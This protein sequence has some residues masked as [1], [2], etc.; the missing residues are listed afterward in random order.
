MRLVFLPLLLAAGLA[1]VAALRPG[2]GLPVAW[3]RAPRSAAQ[4][5]VR[6]Y[7]GAEPS[8]KDSFA[9]LKAEVPPQSKYL[10]QLPPPLAK[11]ATHALVP[12]GLLGGGVVGFMIAP[13]S[14]VVSGAVGLLGG[15][16]TSL[17]GA[18]ARRKLTVLK[19]EAAFEALLE[20]LES[21][22]DDFMTLD[23]SR[24]AAI[25][26]SFG[27]EPRLWEDMKGE[28]YERFMLAMLKSPEFKTNELK[29]LIALKDALDMDLATLS[30]AI[31]GAVDATFQKHMLLATSEITDDPESYERMTMDKCIYL[32][33]SVMAKCDTD[34]G[35]EYGMARCCHRLG[36]RLDEI[37]DR[38]LGIA[39]PLYRKALLT[40]TSRVDELGPD[41]LLKAR[42]TLGVDEETSRT[43]HMAVYRDAM[44]GMLSAQPADGD[45]ATTP[46][47]DAALL[48]AA[49][50]EQLAKLKA[51]MMMTD[52]ETDEVE[53]AE[54]EPLHQRVLDD[55]LAALTSG[56]VDTGAAVA[57][58]SRSAEGYLIP[59]G[60]AT[61]ML[62]ATLGSFLVKVYRGA[63]R[64][65]G[66][67]N[68]DALVAAVNDLLLARD[69]VGVLTLELKQAGML[70][71]E[72]DDYIEDAIEAL[73]TSFS[74]MPHGDREELLRSYV[75]N[76]LQ[77]AALTGAEFDF[78]TAFAFRD[79]LVVDETTFDRIYSEVVEPLV[80][81]R[82]VGAVEAG[83]FDNETKVEFD[84]FMNA[85]EVP[86][87]LYRK[88]ATDLYRKEVATVSA[89]GAIYTPSQE[90]KL[91]KMAVFMDVDPESVSKIHGQ[92][93]A[94]SY[95]QAVIEAMGA[96]GTGIID[97]EYHEGLAKLGERLKLTE[98]VQKSIYSK[99]ITAKVNAQVEQ[100]VAE[101]ERSVLSKEELGVKTGKDQGE[102]LFITAKD[103]TLGLETKA[104][105]MLE[106]VN[107]VD[108]FRGNR[109]IQDVPADEDDESSE[110][111]YEYL[112]TAEG[113]VDGRMLRDVYRHFVVNS[114][115]QQQ[116]QS[117][118]ARAERIEAAKVHIGSILGIS[119][120]EQKE[121]EQELGKTVY[122]QYVDN[123]LKTKGKLEPQDMQ[124]LVNVQQMLKMDDDYCFDLISKMTKDFVK[125]QISNALRWGTP[126][127]P[128]AKQLRTQADA[129]GVDLRED[130]GL[131]VSSVRIP[132]FLAEVEHVIT[133]GEVT[134]ENKEAISD[135]QEAWGIETDLAS[136]HFTSLVESRFKSL[137]VA[138]NQDLLL[139]RKGPAVDKLDSLLKFMQFIPTDLSS[140]VPLTFNERHNLV[141]VF[142]DAKAAPGEE[143]APGLDLLSL[144]LGLAE[145]EEE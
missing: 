4:P 74:Q 77:E 31:Y 139:G 119:V 144:A 117:G 90:E 22:G 25:R 131:G 142:T 48:S 121:V 122:S 79:L 8:G 57:R 11:L 56:G 20:L 54:L 47:T 102:D 6:M 38:C 138:A 55:V 12:A 28:V 91:A 70:D 132:L 82:L 67:R 130:I 101:F 5:R 37:L 33:S 51:L 125:K 50:R 81:G 13:A 114:M 10:R 98:A 42:N 141:D 107:L 35:Y 66:L 44:R 126:D 36:L 46:A 64:F 99:A 7:V 84:L 17:A 80:K 112:V 137:A 129:M 97:D 23:A 62:R 40:A 16:A 65:V 87:D 94:P 110:T 52:E 96:G 3:S 118:T 9:E 92:V 88:T 86:V 69:M 45:E 71:F 61:E 104:N 120:T 95:Q 136:D 14:T 85:L 75:R 133:S 21:A 73:G 140:K 2:M 15:Y 24:V 143:D 127:G 72:G 26:E 43:M 108:F 34:E 123:I 49:D 105:V 134:E 145:D 76:Q 63:A 116:Q 39:S 103:S 32:G 68:T 41:T 106:I 113:M 109:L 78:M 124:F 19:E 18:G 27:V 53:T 30:D 59:T 111:T 115:Q 93:C 29:E 128:T 100:L 1:P 135:I 83:E 60:R 58:I 89:G